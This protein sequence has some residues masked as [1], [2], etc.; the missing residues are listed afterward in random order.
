MS[1][2]ASF[3]ALGLRS[4]RFS[5]GA[6]FRRL[7]GLY[8]SARCVTDRK[9]FHLEYKR[10]VWPNS[11]ACPAL[12]VTELRRNHQLPLGTDRHELNRLAPALDNA[13]YRKLTGLSLELSNSVP[14]TSAPR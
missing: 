14:S 3:Q 8:A 6:L 4:I 5:G 12:S 10:C 11:R 2:F 1:S 7:S 9:Q 13:L